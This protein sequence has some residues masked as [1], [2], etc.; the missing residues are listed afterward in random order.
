M[1]GCAGTPEQEEIRALAAE[2]PGWEAW[3]S[4]NGMWHARVIGSSPI[5]ML[6]DETAA[7]IGTQISDR[8][9]AL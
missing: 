5:V 1:S 4:L 9:D 2:Y 7:G 8:E 6:H 3:R